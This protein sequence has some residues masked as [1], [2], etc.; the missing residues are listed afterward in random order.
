[1][2]QRNRF[3]G[4]FLLHFCEEIMGKSENFILLLKVMLI[5]TEVNIEASQSQRN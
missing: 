1:M 5:K 4:L 2:T 3:N